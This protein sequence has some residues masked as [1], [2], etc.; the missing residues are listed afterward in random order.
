M[1]RVFMTFIQLPLYFRIYAIVKKSSRDFA[2]IASTR[3]SAADAVGGPMHTVATTWRKIRAV[4][5]VKNK[6]LRNHSNSKEIF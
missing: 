2:V 4:S 5:S 3:P 1:K 6:K